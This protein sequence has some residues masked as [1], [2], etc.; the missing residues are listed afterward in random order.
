MRQKPCALYNTWFCVAIIMIPVTL[1]MEMTSR[2]RFNEQHAAIKMFLNKTAENKFYKYLHIHCRF[3]RIPP[4]KHIFH[5]C[6]WHGHGNRCSAEQA[7][8]SLDLRW[9][10]LRKQYF[11]ISP[12]F[13]PGLFQVLSSW[14]WAK[15]RG[16][17]REKTRVYSLVPTTESLEQARIFTAGNT[18]CVIKAWKLLIS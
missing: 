7:T 17:A 2:L 18:A 8:F 4:D 11:A 14:G 13:F 5:W 16:Q 10:D 12:S 1:T 9:Q 3:R 15:K 6:T